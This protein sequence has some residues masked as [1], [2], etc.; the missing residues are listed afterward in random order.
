MTRF[1]TYIFI[2]LFTFTTTVNGTTS[3]SLKHTG[4]DKEQ[5]TRAT[6]GKGVIEVAQGSDL[7]GLN[8]DTSKAQE[9]TK[10]MTT[11]ALDTTANI[12]NRVFTEEGRADIAK[13]HENLGENLSQI[14]KQLQKSYEKLKQQ[15]LLKLTQNAELDKELQKYK[16]YGFAKELVESGA[17][18]RLVLEGVMFLLGYENVDL[19]PDGTHKVYDDGTGV[20]TIGYGHVITKMDR[21][22]NRFTEEELSHGITE[23]KARDIFIS[24]LKSPIQSAV[25]I[26]KTVSEKFSS[27]LTDKQFSAIV[28]LV[29]NIGGGNWADS[30]AFRELRNSGQV[31]YDTWLKNVRNRKGEYMPGLENRRTAEYEIYKGGNYEIKQ[32]YNR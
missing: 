23:D 13:Q 24:D 22:T 31:S 7:T 6:I 9:I 1:L 5:I 32:L 16:Q 26:N 28:S 20:L 14:G 10:D 30:E 8:R 3:V 11:G 27:P 17:I 21:E 15:Q 19:N 18:G 29:F 12:D 4:N 25:N 2:L